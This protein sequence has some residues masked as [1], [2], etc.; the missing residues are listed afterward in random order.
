MLLL[1][2]HDSLV[3]C[4]G[5]D[6]RV[7]VM[8]RRLAKLLNVRWEWSVHSSGSQQSAVTQL[9]RLKDTEWSLIAC[10][11]S[12]CAAVRMSGSSCRRIGR[13]QKQQSAA[14]TRTTPSTHSAAGTVHLHS[15][16]HSS[17]A[18]SSLLCRLVSAMRVLCGMLWTSSMA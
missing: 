10:W 5:Y 15:L 4:A 11:L 6:A 9:S 3:R 2:L 1:V 17:V 18:E 13:L 7:R 8:L 12:E 14:A 16:T